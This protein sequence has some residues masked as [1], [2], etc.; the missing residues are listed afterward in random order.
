MRPLVRGGQMR[1]RLLSRAQRASE[2]EQEGASF[3]DLDEIGKIRRA[4]SSVELP[5]AGLR[6]AAD[7]GSSR[8]RSRLSPTLVAVFGTAMGVAVVTCA[9]ARSRCTFAARVT[10]RSSP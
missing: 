7:G 10:R 9:L 4:H 5:R 2:R 1:D 6:A 3:G 8:D